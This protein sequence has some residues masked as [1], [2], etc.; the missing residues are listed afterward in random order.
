[1]RAVRYLTLLAVCVGAL[2]WVGAASALIVPQRSIAGIELQMTRPEVKD[3]KG[4]PDRIVHGTNDFGAY[5]QFIYKNSAGR[6][7]ATF[8]GNAGA[9]AV[10]TNRETQKTAEGVHVGSPESALHDAYPRLHCRTESSDFR[11]CWT[12]RMR[13]GHRVTDYWIGIASGNVKLITVAFVI[14]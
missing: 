13:P 1:M 7:I 6:L 11:H 5:T 10:R 3:K 2:A 8:Q 14:D 12:G 9:T 4:D